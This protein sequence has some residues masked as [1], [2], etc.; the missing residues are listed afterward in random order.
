M[1]WKKPSHQLIEIFNCIAPEG[2]NIEK[3]NMFGY[4]CRFVN[5]NMFMGLF[6]NNVFLRLS[7]QDRE[8]FL[9][10][11]HAQQFE[12]VSGRIMKEYVV[13]PSWM[14]NDMSTLQ[15]WVKKSL[16]FVLSLPPKMKKKKKKS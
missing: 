6:H 4:P 11:E 14:M 8:R 2:P 15:M 16:A 9:R 1:K 13:V 12:P 5:N 10:L 3:R 7:E